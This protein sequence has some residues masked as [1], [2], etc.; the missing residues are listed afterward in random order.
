MENQNIK[1]KKSWM[2]YIVIA[3]VLMIVVAFAVDYN[4]NSS[5]DNNAEDIFTN[6]A[7]DD[8][9]CG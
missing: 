2:K 9:S 1:K 5:V 3:I 8:V 6:S 4:T 7:F